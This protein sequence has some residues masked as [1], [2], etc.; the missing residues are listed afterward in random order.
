MFGIDGVVFDLLDEVGGQVDVELLHLS[1]GG[2]G[3]DA[4]NL[5]HVA[6]Q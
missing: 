5:D 3:E 4:S 2:H 6:A 1:I